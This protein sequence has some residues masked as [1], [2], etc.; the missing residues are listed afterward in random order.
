LNHFCRIRKEGEGSGEKKRIEG[1]VIEYP[2]K[3]K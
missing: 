2:L 3:S 1:E